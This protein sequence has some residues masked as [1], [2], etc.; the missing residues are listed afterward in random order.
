MFKKVLSKEFLLC[1]YTLA[2]FGIIFLFLLN[3]TVISFI[4]TGLI[5][6]ILS[7]KLIDFK[8]LLKFALTF[9]LIQLIINIVFIIS[10]EYSYLLFA[11]WIYLKRVLSYFAMSL[12]L[13]SIIF[14]IVNSIIYGIKI[15]IKKLKTKKEEI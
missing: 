2:V 7:E 15:L 13:G 11:P 8:K 9:S 5:F 4:I 14:F 3:N 6:G 1:P 12:I 10:T